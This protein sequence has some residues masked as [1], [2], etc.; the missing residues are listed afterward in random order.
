MTRSANTDLPS[1]ILQEAEKVVV[2]SGHQGIN[3]RRLASKLGISATAIYHY[4]ESKDAIIRKLR[5]RSAGMLNDRIRT[6]DPSLPPPDYLAELG[7]QYLAFA[8][9]NPRLYQLLFEVPFDER[10]EAEDRPILYFTYFAAR[11]AIERFA[12]D[13]GNK[14]APDMDPRYSAMMGWILLHGFSSLMMSGMLPPAEGM[15]RETL[16]EVFM[17]FYAHGGREG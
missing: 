12:R 14:I 5:I 7:R 6:I 10:T 4:F 8:Q 2:T 3:M 9:E 15:S 17:R 1:R 11:G 16:Q 13:P